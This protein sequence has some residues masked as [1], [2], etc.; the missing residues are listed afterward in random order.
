L[1]ENLRRALLRA[2]LTDEDVAA[3]LEVDP[4]TVR[5]WLEG[6]IPY[7]R[8]RWA[9][10]GLLGLD[11]ADLWP[12]IRAAIAARS[13]PEEIRAVYPNWQAVPEELWLCLFTSAEHEIGILDDRGLLLADQA[14]LSA[15]ADKAQA[16]VN[17]RICLLDPDLSEVTEPGSDRATVREI[18]TEVRDALSRSGPLRDTGVQFRLHAVTLYQSIY[19][20]DGQLLIVQRAYGIPAMRAPAFCLRASGE[21][22]GMIPAYLESFERIWDTSRHLEWPV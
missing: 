10:A 14:V 6:R 7:L 19:R 22:R 18:G 9:L 21:G 4:K 13:R 17:V 8:H 2:R 3:R 16:G 1:N 11:E 15:L 20:G 12:E 5:R